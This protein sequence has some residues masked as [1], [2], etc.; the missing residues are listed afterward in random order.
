MTT[1]IT[2][3]KYEEYETFLKTF[4]VNDFTTMDD[5][6][7]VCTAADIAPFDETFGKM[8]EQY[9]PDKIDVC[10]D[11][12]IVPGISVTYVLSKSLGKEKKLELYSSEGICHVFQDKREERQHC[13]CNGALKCRG[14]CEECQFRS[15]CFTKIWV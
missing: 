13:S 4:K 2:I 12:V 9:Y 8:D 5:W 15:A 10:K 7:K 3:T 11:E 6:L 14:Y 1:K